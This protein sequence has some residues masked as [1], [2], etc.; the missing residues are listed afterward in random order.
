[1]MSSD[2]VTDNATTVASDFVDLLNGTIVLPT[3]DAPW[4]GNLYTVCLA[5]RYVEVIS[6]PQNGDQL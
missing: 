1:M 3:E 5:L 2:H 6:R 4:S